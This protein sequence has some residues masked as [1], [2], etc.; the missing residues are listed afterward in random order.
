MCKHKEVP[1]NAAFCCAGGH[2]TSIKS[3]SSNSQDDSRYVVKLHP[4]ISCKPQQLLA[5]FCVCCVHP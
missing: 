5:V 1:I 3:S 2:A 4:K